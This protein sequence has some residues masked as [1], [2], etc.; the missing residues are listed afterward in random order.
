MNL[1]LV[2]DNLALVRDVLDSCVSAKRSA[3]L[4]RCFDI[5]NMLSLKKGVLK[6]FIWL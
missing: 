3:H 1:L 2:I 6:S 4:R 5:L